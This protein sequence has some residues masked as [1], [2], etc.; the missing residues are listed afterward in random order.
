MKVTK[1]NI[2]PRTS[3]GNVFRCSVPEHIAKKIENDPE[4]AYV[5]EKG[6]IDKFLMLHPQY[7]PANF[8]KERTQKQIQ[9]DVKE[10]ERLAKLKLENLQADLAKEEYDI[11][12]NK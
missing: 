10:N 9:K 4:Y 11:W 1:M 3:D 8:T 12:K 5:W 7:A 6:G 2:S